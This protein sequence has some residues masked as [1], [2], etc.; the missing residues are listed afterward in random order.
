M[1]RRTTPAPAPADGKAASA[2]RLRSFLTVAGAATFAVMA[3]FAAWRRLAPPAPFRAPPALVEDMVFVEVDEI[4][5]AGVPGFWIDRFETTRGAFAAYLAETGAP[6]PV[7]WADPTA[8]EDWPATRVTWAQ[9]S[10]FA[11]RAGKRLPKVE[12]WDA[13][14]RGPGGATFPWGDGFVAACANTLELRLQPD[15]QPTRVGTFESGRTPSGVYDLVGNVAEWTATRAEGF[16][17]PQYVV[18]GS[19]F[20]SPGDVR[21]GTSGLEGGRRAGEHAYAADI[22]FRCVVD[23]A[24]AEEDLRL[25]THVAKLGVRDP[26]GVLFQVRPA[27]AALR[28]G[29]PR[30]ARLL[31]RT[32]RA[33][34][35][36][37]TPAPVEPVCRRAAALLS[38]LGGKPDA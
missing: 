5:R 26:A 37:E 23:A 3:V 9:A 13:A 28:R 14:A 21:A 8:P 30:A 16:G 15:P 17:A 2:G 27:E 24:A 18:R 1:T 35:P 36:P 31:E 11:A 34:R 19:S 25:R 4:D 10:A 6:P 20:A 38:E 7:G 32:L 22:G 12:E 29:G 33:N